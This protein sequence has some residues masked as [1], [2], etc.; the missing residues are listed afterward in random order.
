MSISPALS[1]SLIFCPHFPSSAGHNLVMLKL[2]TRT[3][4]TKR[5]PSAN[6]AICQNEIQVERSSF[7][8]TI[9]RHRCLGCW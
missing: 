6:I 3:S 7:D 1:L 2:K 5:G 9:P 4:Q 8:G